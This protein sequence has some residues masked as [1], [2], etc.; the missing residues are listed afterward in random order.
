MMKHL[1]FI[2]SVVGIFG[3]GR[4]EREQLTAQVDSLRY[5]LNESQEAAQ[6]LMEVGILMDSID[7]SR[8]LLRSSM[9]EGTTYGD[10]VARMNDI[11]NYVKETEKKIADLEKTAKKSMSKASSLAYTIKK[12]RTDLE[13][14]NKEMASLQTLVAQYKSDNSNLVQSISMKDMELAEREERIKLTQQEM[15][16]LQIQLDDIILLSKQTEADSYFARAQ[17]V[18]ET[19]NRT[20][21]APRKK[22]ESRKQ[23]LELYRLAFQ[24]GKE[25]AQ[26]KIEALEK[27]I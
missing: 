23:A 11:N 15:T 21:F 18:E 14:A 24:M 4:Q 19:A 10:Y 16:T 20:R 7:A 9:V 22:K 2:L 8:K 6:T 26:P 17:A 25:E 27:K 12:L 3:C 5:E 1:I 13:N